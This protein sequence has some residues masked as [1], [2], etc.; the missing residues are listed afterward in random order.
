MMNRIGPWILLALLA[1]GT[2]AAPETASPAPVASYRLGP[3]DRVAVSLVDLKEIEIKPA[4]I[5][6][7]GTIDLQLAGRPRAAGLT[8]NELSEEIVRNLRPI[9]RDPRVKVEVVEY[10][11]QPVTIL[12]AVNKP[13][14]HQLRGPR[15]LIEVL[16]MAEGLKPEAGNILKITRLTT[17]G[18]LPLPRARMDASG[19]SSIGE[20][21]VRAL[22][23]ARVPELNVPIRPHDVI[24]IP[25]ADLIYVLGSVRKPGGFA[26]AERE[27]I[28]VLQA[29]SLSEGVDSLGAPQKARILRSTGPGAAATEVP[30]DVRG[31]LAGKQPDQDLRPN[32]VLFIPSNRTKSAGL[33][34]L[35]VGIQL[36]TGIAIF[37][38]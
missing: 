28:T 26:L 34:A 2:S 32:D 17:A 38:R 9:V 29:L 31:I 7:D 19:E 11:S 27:T 21:G 15:H 24:T 10:G 12:G 36:G 25:R 1:P 5:D 35:E 4:L 30:V 14:V 8:C 20:V 22:L 16:A 3:G 37:R 23:E 6:L 18:E 33:R 13:G